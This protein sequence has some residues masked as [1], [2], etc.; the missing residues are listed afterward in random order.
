MSCFVVTPNLSTDRQASARHERSGRKGYRGGTP[1]LQGRHRGR[2]GEGEPGD[3]GRS[4][5]NH[6][7]AGGRWVVEGQKGVALRG[8][9]FAALG[10]VCSEHRAAVPSDLGLTPPAVHCTICSSGEHC[11]DFLEHFALPVGLNES[12]VLFR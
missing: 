9:S 11:C 7:G 3:S 4:G 1:L 8:S 10:N 2:Q 12:V 5:E 6:R